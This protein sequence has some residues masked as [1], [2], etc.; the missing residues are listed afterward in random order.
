MK[1]NE[2][3]LRDLWDTSSGL[4]HVMGIIEGEKRKK[5]AGRISEG[6]MIENFPNLIKHIDLHIQETQ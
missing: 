3:N 2:Q 5:G 6:I 4:T 1:K